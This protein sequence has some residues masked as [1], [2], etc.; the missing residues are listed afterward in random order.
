M[1]NF[2][3]TFLPQ[4][5]LVQIGPLAIHWY[6]LLVASGILAGF[7]AVYYLAKQYGLAKEHLYNLSFYLIIFG[8]IG[9]RLY[10]VIYAWPYYAKHLLDIFKVWQGG[11]AIHGAMIAGLLVIYFYSQKHKLKFTFLTDLLVI[12]LP[13]AMAIGRWGNYFNQELF[14]LPT[15]LPWGIPI[16]EINRPAQFITV[17]YFQPTFLYESLLN[18][19]IFA[20]L[21]GW[22][23]IRLAKNKNNLDK[24]PGLGNITLIY[25][26]LYSLS[27]LSTEFLRLDYSPYFLG[28]RWAQFV[29]VLIIISCLCLLMAKFYYKKI[30]TAG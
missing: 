13:L 15:N 6:G 24:I 8:L 26:I 25:F 19:A 10:Y 22:H 9:D 29:S 18:L 21:L 30:K 12:A 3:H 27:R 23:Q 2:L 16:N 14:G 4:P 11:L 5:I 1:I 28:L 17:P 20:I 7:L